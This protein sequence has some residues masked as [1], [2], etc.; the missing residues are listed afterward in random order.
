M[1]SIYTSIIYMIEARREGAE[2]RARESGTDL[3]R[4]RGSFVAGA[5]RGGGW[6]RGLLLPDLAQNDVRQRPTR[7]AAAAAAPSAAEEALDYRL[8]VLRQVDPVDVVALD[9][10][11]FLLVVVLVLLLDL[12]IIVFLI[13][14]TTEG[15]NAS[16]EKT[17]M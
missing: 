4:Q 15:A 12:D 3:G 1:H 7:Q 8:F 6:P 10:H 5:E 2:S 16:V 9:V 11:E 13:L 17:H 14:R